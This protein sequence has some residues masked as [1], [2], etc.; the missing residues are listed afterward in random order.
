MKISK[1]VFNLKSGNKFMVEMAMFNIQRK[2]SP[3]VGN[4]SNGS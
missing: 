3:K 1:T 2:M 4:Q